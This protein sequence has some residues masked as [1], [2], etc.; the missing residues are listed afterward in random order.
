MRVGIMSERRKEM[1][2]M[3][4]KKVPKK[5]RVYECAF[6]E[7][8]YDDLGKYYWCHNADIPERECNAGRSYYCQQFCPGYKKGRLCG[9]HE[10]S[11]FE[12]KDAEVYK[13][14]LKKDA[15]VLEA[16]ERALLAYLKK[17]YEG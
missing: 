6:Y 14:K 13:A 16:K 3:A 15:E 5:K 10:I 12:K 8:E 11:D 17:K 7:Y 4:K 2:N 1:E 9:T